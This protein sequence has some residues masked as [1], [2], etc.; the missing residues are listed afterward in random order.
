MAPAAPHDDARESNDQTNETSTFFVRALYAYTSLDSSALSF[1]Q[2]DLIEVMST[3]PSGWWDGIHCA[4][5]LRGWFP[6]NYVERASEAEA[7]RAQ[8][9]M[10]A[11]WD[12]EDET[13]PLRSDDHLE[14]GAFTGGV[15]NDL[16]DTEDAHERRLIGSSADAAD[17]WVPKVNQSGEVYYFNPRTGDMSRDLPT[18]SKGDDDWVTARNNA[19]SLST[20]TNTP[21]MESGAFVQPPWSDQPTASS[22]SQLIE[23]AEVLSPDAVDQGVRSLT[24]RGQPLVSTS[25]KSRRVDSIKKGHRKTL[26]KEKASR[27]A[28]LDELLTPPPPPF[29]HDLEALVK[30]ALQ[31]L[32]ASAAEISGPSDAFSERDRLAVLGD[33]V[34]NAIRTLLHA[35]AMFDQRAFSDAIAASRTDPPP[36][37]F[38][39]L[40]SMS[41]RVSS[42]LSKLTLSV[43]AVWGL[44]ELGPVPD[45]LDPDDMALEPEGLEARAAARH[46]M[47]EHAI[48][49][50]QVQQQTELKLRS[51]II[52][53]IRDVQ[54]NVSTF[55]TE[56]ERIFAPEPVGKM[57]LRAPLLLRGALTIDA[58]TLVLPGGGYGGSWR[59]NGFANL[60]PTDKANFSFG[61]AEMPVA[62]YRYPSQPLS[63]AVAS[64]LE[65]TSL[66]I[67]SKISSASHL[68]Q[69]LAQRPQGLFVSEDAIVAAS[70]QVL[71]TLGELL[72][73]T[74]DVDL[75]SS[76]HYNTIK[77][78]ADH[79]EDDAAVVE[80]RQAVRRARSLLADFD[81]TKQAVYDSAAQ[82]LLDLQDIF[83][84]PETTSVNGTMGPQPAWNSPLTTG[85]AAQ[86][87]PKQGEVLIST[88]AEAGISASKLCKVV[89]SLA[90]VS[91]VQAKAPSHL[92][93]SAAK[94]D[95]EDTAQNPSRPESRAT[96]GYPDSMYSHASSLRSGA[97]DD[98]R[99][100]RSVASKESIDSDFYFSN[101]QQPAS[102]SSTLKSAAKGILGPV[103]AVWGKRRGSVETA[104]TSQS[105]LAD[106]RSPSQA[107][108]TAS[109][110]AT[111]LAK[112]LGTES[113]TASSSGWRSAN[114]PLPPWLGPDYNPG[115]VSFGPEGQIRGGTLRALVIAAT[116]HEGRIDSSY[117]SAFLMTYRT[118]CTPYELLDCLAERYTVVE[119]E[120]LT[121]EEMKE[122]EI[123]KL[124]PVRAR[125]ANVI[126]TWVRDYMDT[127]I[128]PEV[129]RRI[130]DFATNTMRD[131]VQSPQI[132]KVVEERMAGVAP[133]G[134]G[135]LAP[136]L[137]PPPL[138]P[139]N[140]RKIK[141]VDID[142]LEVARQIS[143][144]DG[145]LFTKITPQECLGKAWPREFGSDSPN[146]SAMIDMSNA[147]TRWVT[148]TV[149]QQ[150]ETKKRAA[151]IKHFILIAER[152]LTLNNFSTLLHIIA[153]LN[154]TPIHRLRRTW[155]SVSQKSIVSLGILNNLMRPDKN[156]KEYREHLRRVTPPC[157][158]FMGVYLTDWTFIGDGNPDMLREKP[159]QINF[160]KRQKASE[161]ILMIKLHQSTTY[162]L[163][164]VPALA[165]YMQDN[166]FPNGTMTHG[167]KANDDQRLYELSLVREPRERDDEKI[168]RLL[169]E[170]GFL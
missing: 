66:H 155:E 76:I 73:Q 110:S 129:L 48:Y 23:E 43:R 46:R 94:V 65:S 125:T 160:N 22:S 96:G 159:N 16:T 145:K 90:A 157:V 44:P 113:P 75:A 137:P 74:E 53:G 50:R 169:S 86:K 49:E 25:R 80:Y 146:I 147:V 85:W 166:L 13:G 127:D 102:T 42:S 35:T 134:L 104:N 140:L 21:L 30:V 27:K 119:P 161:L 117:L 141:F 115:E 124:K 168:A 79:S 88:L 64:A 72:Q 106:T 52:A 126:K 8:N 128:E 103:G 151:V 59:G 122:W 7:A 36:N 40:R 32:E 45:E 112:I 109:T 2:G 131:R 47:R 84:A 93:P 148:E 170:S 105:S 71:Q 26:S 118:F 142:P 143:I 63:T 68:V 5:K 37:A 17:L 107:S 150:E 164:V 91:D 34:V 20:A 97:Q 9:H 3:L 123:R 167:A 82:I 111:K 62:Q 24:L 28:N 89:R 69:E 55:I 14:V 4:N 31:E 95:D 67:A 153:G 156:Y 139:R 130:A 162:N 38:K 10:Q 29:L 15:V 154:S 70:E 78:D 61:D 54:A 108:L 12:G 51:D 144:M 87:E 99:A 133:R 100:P 11:Y 163:T 114:E 165:Q 132:V 41:R 83:L 152:C 138:V 136:G 18:D 135:N 1:Q 39:A 120:G 57:S 121:P 56:F 101:G 116:S 92:R 6:S 158:P 98:T 149:L 33:A 58:S 60:P 77:D 19:S 81:R